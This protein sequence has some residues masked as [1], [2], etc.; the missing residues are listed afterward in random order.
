MAFLEENGLAPHPV[1]YLVAFEYVL[2]EDRELM[3]EMSAHIER[4]LGWDDALMGGLFERF[5]E[6]QREDLYAGVSTD[7][8]GLLSNLLGQVQ[9]T[10][11]SMANYHKTL[12]QKQSGLKN[13]PSAEALHAIVNDLMLATHDVVVSSGSLQERLDATQRE[14]ETLRQQLEE[15]KREAEHDALTG[16]LNRKALERILGSLHQDADNGGKPY[17]LLLADVDHFKHFNDTYG[18]LLGDEVLKRVVQ[19]LHQ[20]VK[21][22]DFVARYGGEEFLIMLPGTPVKGGLALAEAIRHSVEQIVLVRRSTKER[23]SKVTISLGVGGYRADEDKLA[24]LERVDAALYR[25]KREGRNRVTQ[26][27]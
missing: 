23:L 15:I 8:M 22:G 3:Q 7:L 19:V 1:N 5:I 17:C 13:K 21:G 12:A 24:L 9:D 16:A 10:R 4:R 18:H 11:T 26:A 20:Q 2:G 27:D 6:S 25:A 14:A